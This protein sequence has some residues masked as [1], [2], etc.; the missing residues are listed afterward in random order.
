MRHLLTILVPGLLLVCCDKPGLENVHEDSAVP[1]AQVARGGHAPRQP[2]P[3]TPAELRKILNAAAGIE[4]PE[5]REKTIADVAWNALETDPELAWEALL[6]LPTDGTEKI[7]LLQHYAMRL[8]E[9]NPE[10]ALA[11]ASSLGTSEEVSAACGQIALILAE[12]DPQR[13]ATLLS[14]SGIA[15]RTF[16]VATVQVIQR[17]VAQSP[18]HAAAWVALFPP[19]AAREAGIKIIAE[20]WLACDALAAIVWSGTLHE[21]G[22][23]EEV[24]R[25]MK[26]ASDQGSG[27]EISPFTK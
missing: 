14:E 19:G 8:A 1:H 13:A 16:D 21:E 18:S 2:V 22:F 20:Q 12:T 7:R 6:Q 4:S 11:W 10:E 27:A 25:A 15:G 23:S 3:G 9:R 5:T 24:A 26:G 17:W